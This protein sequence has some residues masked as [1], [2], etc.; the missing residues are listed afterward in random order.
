MRISA[1]GLMQN[2]TGVSFKQNKNI[3]NLSGL[4]V[5]KKYE[6]LRQKNEKEQEKENENLNNILY[7][8]TMS[9][10]INFCISCLIR[11]FSSLCP[12]PFPVPN[13]CSKI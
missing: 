9:I 3:E 7:N 1:A 6:Q 10:F 8:S 5:V 12:R 2:S 13:I 11:F 4:D